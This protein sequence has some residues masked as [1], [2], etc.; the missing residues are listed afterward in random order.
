M[1]HHLHLFFLL[2]F[3]SLSSTGLNAHHFQKV[4]DPENDLAQHGP[5]AGAYTGG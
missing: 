3:F 1:I 2:I 4:T 5:G